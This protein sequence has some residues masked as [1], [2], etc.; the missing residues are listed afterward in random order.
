MTKFAGLEG[1][2]IIANDFTEKAQTV[3]SDEEIDNCKNLT[4][5]TSVL[6]ESKIAIECGVTAMHDI[7]EGGVLGHYM[8]F[9]QR[10]NVALF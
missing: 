3:L 2:A 1:T 4:Q 8:R 9:V 10:L 7:T 6:K 5:Y